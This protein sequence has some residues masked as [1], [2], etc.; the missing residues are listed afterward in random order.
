MIYLIIYLVC[1]VIAFLLF[2]VAFGYMNIRG[3][4]PYKLYHSLIWPVHLIF[5][6]IMIFYNPKTNDKNG[7]NK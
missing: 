4:F 1:A 2:T 5:N 7:N 3:K 6:I